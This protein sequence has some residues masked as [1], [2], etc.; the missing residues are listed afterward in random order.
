MFLA[1]SLVYLINQKNLTKRILGFDDEG[2]FIPLHKRASDV[3]MFR[4]KLKLL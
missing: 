3:A 4:G 1:L 2:Q